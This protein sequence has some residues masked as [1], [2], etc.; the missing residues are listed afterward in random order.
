MVNRWWAP[1]SGYRWEQEALDYLRAKMAECGDPYHAWQTFTFTARSGQ[2]R[3][4]DLLMATPSGLYL[5]EIKSHPGRA[6]N[7]GS[8]WTFRGDRTRTIDNPLHLTDL[9][10]KELKGQLKWARDK[11]GIRPGDLRIPFVQPVV[12]LA[13]PSLRCAFDEVQRLNVYG[14][15]E[16]CDQTG[17]D[18]IW[19]GLLGKRPP[20]PRLDARVSR[21]LGKLLHTIGISGLRNPGKVGSL[22][23][24]ERIDVGEGWEDWLARNP[25]MPGDPP[26]RVRVYFTS[27]GATAADRAQIRRAANREY[28]ALQGVTHE[29]IVRADN[30]SDELEAG[31]AIVFRHGA[32]WR[33]LD[34]FMSERGREL[35]LETRVEMA[36]QL[37][38][39]VDHAHRRN[40]YHRSLSA[41]GVYVEMDGRYP[42]LRIA[43]WQTAANRAATRTTGA[44]PT[45]P[46]TAL[47]A[48]VDLDAD[49]YLAPEFAT[50]DADGAQL[51]VFG[52]GALTYLLLTG[53]PPADDRKELVQR[54]HD[55]RNLV[56]SAVV[57]D[58][59]A[60]MDDLVRGSTQVNAADR[61]ENVR[62]FLEYLDLVEEE[63]TEPGEIVDPLE[64][65]A[66][67]IIEGWRVEKILGKGSTSRAL[68]LTGNGHERVLKV[69]LND[70]AARRLEREAAQL[71]KLNETHDAHI[72][73]LLD[74]PRRL[75]G[76]T[77]IATEYA[78]GETLARQLRHDGPIAGVEDLENLGEDLLSAIEHLEA[79]GVRH[80]DIK[81]DNLA[82][83]EAP[84]KRRRLMLFDFSL[85]GADDEALGAGTRPYLDPFLGGDRRTY[86][87]A[88]EM[89]AAA[90]T[91]HQMASG[92]TPSWGDG[93]TE[94]RM[95]D[96]EVPQLW[97]DLFDP[98]LRDGLAAFFRR[99]LHR[100]AK[101]RFP[102]VKRMRRAWTDVFAA[103]D[104]PAAGA[105]EDID[106]DQVRQE[107]AAR[108]GLDTPL[109]DAG[110]PPR[111][112]S[113]AER[114]LGA[115]T[116]GDLIKIPGERIR[117]L[118]GV[119]LGT[120][121]ELFRQARAWRERLKV[122]QRPDV[123]GTLV[124]G[125][126]QARVDD[127]VARLLP[128][129][130]GRNDAELRVLRIA[131]ALPDPDGNRP[132]L[133]PWAT[134]RE[135]GR[136]A[137]G[138]PQPH[139]ASIWNAARQRWRKL[140]A[141]MKALR[142][143]VVAIIAGQGRV[144]ESG[145]IAV[146]LLA[147]R[148]CGLD[149]PMT[150]LA[151][152]QAA[153]RAAIET[154]ESLENPRLLRRRLGRGVSSVPGERGARVLV[155]L[156]S[157]DPDQPNERDL[158]DY[159]E[160]L[161]ARADALVTAAAGAEA[162]PLPGR[163]E[164]RAALT[165][166]PRDP[167]ETIAPMAD[168]DLVRLAAAASVTAAA[169]ERLELYPRDLDH[170]R[171]LRLAQ[172]GAVFVPGVVVDPAAVR[173][174]VAARFPDLARVD[175]LA[176]RAGL[177]VL[178]QRMGLPTDYAEGTTPDGRRFAGLLLDM[179][180]T[181]V[182]STARTGPHGPAVRVPGAD[183]VTDT[184]LRLA[185]AAQRGG[186][187]ALKTY[188]EVSAPA[189]GVVAD[190]PGVVPVNVTAE[191]VTMLRAVV[192]EFGKPPWPTVVK[193]DR[194][195]ASPAARVGFAKRVD[196]VWRRL[197]ERVRAAG[198]HP[199]TAVLL[200]DTAPLTR[201]AGGLDLLARLADSARRPD[202]GP[203]GL[204]VLC[205]M[206][207][208]ENDAL[209]DDHP[210]GVYG[211]GEQLMLPRDF[212]LDAMSER[213]AS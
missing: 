96:E 174:R 180:V 152:A 124:A 212:I 82:V 93:Q 97:E 61:F 29:G 88:A 189:A 181:A 187:L 99:A 113:V 209:L 105:G 126:A 42:R 210:I 125:A 142:D 39:A 31:P 206:G 77:V 162:A 54:L 169:T 81:P 120:K 33:R 41:R 87:T 183:P 48:R 90:V 2:V 192:E 191:F 52:L 8:V 138:I 199:G 11:L 56:P 57:D 38:E 184:G 159:A 139:V 166:V 123:A 3:E 167:D 25:A 207:Q 15:D 17:L 208:P 188:T 37:A 72:V 171:A 170:L 165:Q 102:D 30:F 204:W 104:R 68:L 155:A 55:E 89:Y 176:D 60:N 85:A 32:D 24:T 195:D 106:A 132:P 6:T 119:G 23:L 108:A 182:T 86:D 107:A 65:T 59:T 16:L 76:R 150:R 131:L 103:L 156:C 35:P 198:A 53:A 134:Q 70:D 100:D 146:E 128:A 161:G 185:A 149:D 122:A 160:R 64:A 5:V 36:R 7:D 141:L 202:E 137:G 196:E 178:L 63:L 157:D 34:L 172:A 27:R 51:D 201:Y 50:P 163:A 83:R 21:Q 129:P 114:Q 74:G 94:E 111:A 197:A 148:G 190:R 49:P 193:A 43:N 175:D 10:A 69:A 112:L 203:W 84:K 40:L 45:T 179:P 22:E 115:A 73:R 205:P 173:D 117:R 144:M 67:A 136:A 143:E 71:A 186:F 19:S 140:G 18:G 79:E 194:P 14:R 75:G 133:L 47:R 211:S 118:R 91:L 4:C 46:D 130:D 26:R 109:P 147:R 13:D 116:V 44:S 98:N 95:L 168:A 92:E 121:N 135:V 200:H 20:A 28:L 145:Q 12:F 62:E 9:K 151:H 80:R 110:L 177:R 78:G 127:L 58:M 66:G 158:L 154:E 1:K 101:R 213:A 164:L 153:V